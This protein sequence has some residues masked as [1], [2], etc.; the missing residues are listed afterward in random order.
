MSLVAMWRV[1]VSSRSCEAVVLNLDS[2]VENESPIMTRF[3]Y[4][5]VA[6]IYISLRSLF[7]SVSSLTMCDRCW[8]L[9]ANSMFWVVS[10]SFSSCREVVVFCNVLQLF[11]K[12]VIF[13]CKVMLVVCRL[14]IFF[15]KL[16]QLDSSC[17]LMCSSDCTREC[18]D[19]L[20]LLR[21]CM[22]SSRSLWMPR[23]RLTMRVS[24][25]RVLQVK[26][27]TMLE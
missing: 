2:K 7:C 19:W 26:R 22:D 4:R 8:L 12:V 23:N 21:S 27:I 18:R 20:E 5:L 13:F 24:L 9:L 25:Y 10:L 11:C 6:S 14:V 17:S 15:C 3:L 1:S 16:S